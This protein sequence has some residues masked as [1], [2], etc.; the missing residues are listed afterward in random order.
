MQTLNGDWCLESATFRQDEG[1]DS[2]F[3]GHD[4]DALHRHRTDHQGRDEGERHTNT[5]PLLTLTVLS[6]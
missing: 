2:D 4:C 1:S 3:R 5:L 6:F